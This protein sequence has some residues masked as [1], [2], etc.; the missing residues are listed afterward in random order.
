MARLDAIG[1]RPAALAAY[2]KLAERLRRELRVAP[3]EPTW[4]LAEQIRT[5]VADA[6][7]ARSRPGLLP[8]VG[9]E[10]ELRAL[11]AAWTAACTGRGGL[12]LVHGDPGIGKT[13]L[14]TQLADH[15]AQ[16]GAVV[17][18]GAA[19]DLA[20]PPLAPWIE[21][22]AGL[23]R[24]LGELPDTPWVL[25]L[26]A[27][28]PAHIRTG[29]ADTAP[30]MEEARLIEAVVA[31]LE[32]CARRGPVLVVLEDL[33][34]ADEA[35]L[36][37]LSS[38]T[39]RV[40]EVRVL[41]VA[42]RRERPVRDRLVTL[43]HVSRQGGTV[44][45]D[46][47]LGPLDESAISD[48]ARAVGALG[49]DAVGR[50]VD[51]ADGNALL[52]VEAARALAIGDALPLGLRGAVRAAAARLPPEARELV[53]TLAV[54]G[55]DVAAAEAAKRA[56][57][58]LADALPPAEDQGLL[59]CVDDRVRFRHGLLREAVYADMSSIERTQRHG[60]A[61][62]LLRGSLDRAAEASA[63]LRATGR[64]RDAGELL[65]EAAAQARAVGAL[66]DATELLREACIALPDD[67]VPALALADAY[68]WRGRPADSQEAFSKAL[69]LLERAGD[70]AALAAAHLRFAEWHYG[71][72]C[73]PRV[74]VESCRRALAVMDGAGVD[75]PQLRAQI[76]SV[77]AWCESIGGD[78]AEVERALGML[79]AVA[80]DEPDDPLI[81]CAA[82]RTRCFSLLRM[83]YFTEAVEP[84]LRAAGAAARAG[85]PDQCYAGL[86]N[87]AFGYAAAGDLE[88]A[89]ELL[90]RCV[91][92]IWGNGLLAIETLVLI[93]RAWVLARLRRF[94]DAAE[95]AA[96]ARRT[97]N[98]LDSADLQALV[99]AE[100]GRVALLAG[101][102]QLA[103]DLLAA[104]LESPDASIGRP[105]A[106]LQ[107]AE[108]LA[109]HGKL[110]D[111]EAELA[112]V[113]L[114]PVRPGDW[115][116]TLVA[117]MS[118][119]EGLIAAGRGDLVQ[120]ERRLQEAAAG[121]RHRL[122]PAELGQRMADV[123]VDLGRP[124]IGLVVPTEELAIVEADLGSLAAGTEVG[125]A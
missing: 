33:H 49:D 7:T 42:T 110:D 51:A 119:V 122:S 41:V 3:S 16:A 94:A 95:A 63:H 52:A 67:P 66:A 120:A 115:P 97:A 9:R 31:L 98:R 105:L 60:R 47:A 108:A 17:A 15:A 86:V 24:S 38:I 118:G 20:G 28:L 103:A 113:V 112:A 53:R 117:R 65:V 64:L 121:W 87:A 88:A 22:C 62:E 34:A 59:E 36:A 39:R 81:A 78:L 114:E 18:T 109:R 10:V 73:Q 84:G 69:P 99:D 4:R 74:A 76:L 102:Y 8:L 92:E 29:V 56:G 68:A 80:G 50:V 21:V 35:S 46:V 124:I 54:A 43:E 100:R 83:G 1:D 104:A 11:L 107:R 75:A 12:A 61:A 58:V 23:V 106:R 85:R 45:A 32:E 111:A 13:R 79:A 44:R 71:P 91:A 55:R 72:I 90:D 93:D 40:M 125:R 2:Q 101:D 30:G 48:L 82:A 37:M 77:Y 5:H 116:D 70:A 25:A 123:M 14:V 19:P 57:V 26:A 6:P 27:L 89:L 96:Q